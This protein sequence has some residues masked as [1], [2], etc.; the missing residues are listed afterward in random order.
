VGVLAPS[1]K[2]QRGPHRSQNKP[3]RF[4]PATARARMASFKLKDAKH[5][6][7]SAQ[8]KRS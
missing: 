1:E 4:L 7:K 5:L 8:Q 6:L 3:K 2:L